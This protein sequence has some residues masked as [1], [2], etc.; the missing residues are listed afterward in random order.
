MR[1]RVVLRHLTTVL[2]TVFL[3]MSSWAQTPDRN[4]VDADSLLAL[5]LKEDTVRKSGSL[6]PGTLPPSDDALDSRVEYKAR[7]SMRFDLKLKKI[8]LYGAADVKY[9]K[10]H[11]TA[12][13]IEINWGNNVVHAEGRPDSTGKIIGHPVFDEGTQTFDADRMDYNFKTKKGRISGIFTQQ[14]DG[15]IHGEQVK[16][17]EKDEFYIRNG[18]Y[19]TCNLPDHPHFY[20][21]AS[22]I[23]VMP[24]DKIVSGPANLWIEDVPTPLAVPFGI[25]P[26]STKRKSGIIFPTYGESPGLGFYLQEGGYYFGINDYID[27]SIRGN[28]YSRGSWGLSGGT[29][30]NYRYHFNGSLDVRFSKILQGDPELLGSSINKDFFITWKHTQ[31]PKS[32]PNS[33][34]SASV[35][36]GSSNY[37][38]LNSLN[39]NNIVANTFTS[40]ISYA[41]TFANTPFNMVISAGHSQ[42]TAT[43]IITLSAPELQV[44]MNRYYPFKRK[45]PIGKQKEYEKIGITYTLQSKNTISQA[46][47]LYGRPGWTQKFNNG[48]QHQIPISTSIQFL[49]FFTFTP[50]FNYNE[51]WY[52]NTIEKYYDE[53]TGTVASDTIRGFKS[54]REW[55]ASANVSTRLYGF[56]KLGKNTVRNVMTPQVSYRYQP[57]FSTRRYG[58]YGANGAVGYYSPYENGLYGQPSVGR[59]GT[60]GITLN[61]NLE[62][63]FKSKRDTTG[64]GLKKVVLLDAFNFSTGYNLAA[65][66]LNWQNLSINARTKLFKKIDVVYSSSHDFYAFDTTSNARINTFEYDKTG[67]LFRNL[68]T[69]LSLTTTLASGQKQKL[70]SQAGTDEERTDLSRNPNSYVDFTIPWSLNA[71]FVLGKTNTGTST[72]VN[73]V[74]NVSG[75]LNLTSKWKIGF[76]TGYDF[77]VKE[78]SLTTIDIFRDLHCW[79]MH[80]YWI[81]YGFRQSYNFTINV[82]SS[83]L[84]DLKVNRRRQWYDLQNQ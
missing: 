41:K 54:T 26:N 83:M 46:D 64:T 84:Q 69:S 28:I 37:N 70:S 50:A 31:D 22:K 67:H 25:F 20:I 53:K 68:S 47:S 3:G 73:Q 59:Q 80:F 79:E 66:S 43:K 34:F 33:R 6:P 60:V 2:F 21:N 17:S 40:S 65:D 35:Q 7:D 58:F 57:D 10:I 52:F 44:N 24:G 61:N 45:N 12:D 16:K 77:E 39:A 55:N 29:S 72:K 19:T 15:Y 1:L 63:K 75:D 81:P 36:A 5:Q 11:L 23:K 71:G 32:R 42:N 27:A 56:L 13:Y 9:D 74:L 4:V 78:F 14:G 48:V 18:K 30:Y 49:R 62:G 76:S 51:R 38:K 82:K 8:F